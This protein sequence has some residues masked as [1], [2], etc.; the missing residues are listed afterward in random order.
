VVK[1]ECYEEEIAPGFAIYKKEGEASLLD[2]Q[3]VM[4]QQ[5]HIQ[6]Q[7]N[8]NLNTHSRCEQACL[9]S[10]VKHQVHYHDNGREHD[11]QTRDVPDDAEVLT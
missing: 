6:D 4:G 2:E 5:I 9:L 11:E 1:A 3:L 8:F 10:L 7:P